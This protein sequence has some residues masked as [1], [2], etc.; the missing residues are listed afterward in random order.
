MKFRVERDVLADAVAWAACSLPVRPSVPVLAGLLIEATDDGLVLSSFDYE[1]S[2]RATLSAQ[3]SDE[4]WPCER[5]AARR[6]LPQPARPPVDMVLDGAWVSLTCGSARFSLQ[7]M[8]VEDYPHCPTCPPR[9]APSTPRVRA[10]GRPGGHRRRSRRHA[11]GPHRR[12]DRDRRRHDLAARHRP[13]PA[14]TAS[15]PGTPARPTSRR[16]RSSRPG[17]SATPPSRSPP[18]ARV[19][20]A[21]ATTGTGEG[22]IGLRVRRPAAYVA[23]PRA[24]STASS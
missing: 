19:T 24:C 17:C 15:S 23:R 1:T 11:A 3:V 16:P 20:I 21:L 10:R 22:I 8:P 18:A 13:F 9:P 12:P 6:H 2:A 14:R 5:P 4:A 7:T